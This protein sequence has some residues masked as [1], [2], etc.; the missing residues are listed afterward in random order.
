MPLA[1]RHRATSLYSASR[2]GENWHGSGHAHCRLLP[3]TPSSRHQ[4]GRPQFV[5]ST[6]DRAPAAATSNAVS[7]QPEC[8][9]NGRD[10]AGAAPVNGQGLVATQSQLNRHLTQVGGVPS[11]PRNADCCCSVTQATTRIM[12]SLPFGLSRPVVPSP[13]FHDCIRR[14]NALDDL[15]GNHHLLDAFETRQ[16]EHWFMICF[17]PKFPPEG[18]DPIA[19]NSA[20]LTH[21]LYPAEAGR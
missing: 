8:G 1:R 6:R 9:V 12:P 19:F 4:S 11:A 15:L 7:L 21:R 5:D 14:R 17:L 10:G 13:T 16:V 3:I 20:K 18:V 2:I